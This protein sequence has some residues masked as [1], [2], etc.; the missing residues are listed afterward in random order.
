MNR[1]RLIIAIAAVLLAIPLIAAVAVY[2]L[3]GTDQVRVALERQ[4]TTWLGQPVAIG[5]ATARIFPRP[6]INLRDVR[7][8]QPVRVALDQVELSTGLRPLLSR[9]IEDAEVAISN[10]RI[11]MPLPFSIPAPSSPAAPSATNAAANGGVQILSVR[12]IALH[13]ITIA[14]RGRQVVISADSSLSSTHL[15]LDKLTATSGATS[16]S[17]S[18]LVQLE[19]RLDAQLKVLANRIDVDDLV[20]LADA[21]SPRAKDAARTSQPPAGSLQLPGRIVAHISAERG[22]ASG[23]DV[24]QFA[25]TLV[26]QGN[27]ITLSPLSFQLFDGAY[28]GTIDIDARASELQATVRSQITN[29]DVAKLAAFGGEADAISGRLSGT[30]TFN[31]RGMTVGDAVANAS[32]EGTATIS[33]GVLPH[34]GLVRTVVLFFGTPAPNGGT[35]SDRFDRID[36]TFGLVRRV[37]AARALSLH[38]PDLDLVGQGTLTIP[39]KAMEGK[40]DLSLSEALSQQAG[41]TFARYTREG[42]RI[43][44]PAIVSGTL[45]NPHVNIDA[46][47]AIGRGLR[48]EVQERLKSILGGLIPAPQD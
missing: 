29:I 18:G 9:R 39:T 35:S 38:S 41:S 37:V 47:A 4:A 1:R 13:N 20:A 21:F 27:R 33:N 10:S 26:A 28:H 16:L 45:S 3:L 8:G 17:A 14:S 30:G 40:F 43:V 23:V 36:A 6:S 2:A 7:V 42:N 19:P 48:N 34:L 24:Q 31:G 46:G 25:T 15:N 12:S 44:L 22:R 32:G 11:D 5:S